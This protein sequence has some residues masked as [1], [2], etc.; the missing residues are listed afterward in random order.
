MK[1]SDILKLNDEI[2]SLNIIQTFL[3]QQLTQEEFERAAAIYL[4]IANINNLHDIVL[5]Q[6]KQFLNKFYT[7]SPTKYRQEMY[8]YLID[9]AIKN[10][11]YIK[12]LF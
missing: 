8:K 3:S 7:Q 10:E 5:S 2:E 1:L 9:S 4:K 6:G 11:D 12:I